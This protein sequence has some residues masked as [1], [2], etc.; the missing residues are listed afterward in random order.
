MMLLNI[1]CGTVFHPEWINIDVD[2]LSDAVQECDLR[3]GLPFPAM[4]MDACYSSH[5]LEH[6]G[7]VE[8]ERFLREQ[9]RVLR[10]GGI[11]RVVVPDL[12]PICRNYLRFLDE[13]TAG[14]AAHEFRY[15]YSYIEMYDQVLR[16]ESGG[17]LEALWSSGDLPDRDWVFS[18]AG[19]V[20]A[21]TMEDRAT[22]LM[23]GRMP[24]IERGCWFL[25]SVA[26]RLRS[27]ALR[28]RLFSTLRGK[29]AVALVRLSF[30]KD[31]A[32]ALRVGLFRNSGQIHRVMYDR[33]RLG[34]LLR[35]C[36]FSGVTVCGPR[37]SRIP[38]F[39]RFELDVIA[40][41]SRKPD[42]LY[43]EAASL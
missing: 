6:L 3:R 5:V 43:M 17:Q 23:D 42:S 26:A 14:D 22:R 8:S 38:D 28:R 32:E 36:G 13:L 10:S 37:E 18:R 25:K 40:G 24:A 1:G 11:I 39:A 35:R 31:A 27:R 21:A 15:D 33:F 16:E 30:G 29:G 2:A 34:R 12:E 7:P 20:V 41:K 9:R 4:S 19:S